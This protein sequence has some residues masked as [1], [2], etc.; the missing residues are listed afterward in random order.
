MNGVLCEV[1]VNYTI[2]GNMVRL[3]DGRYVCS[4]C[5]NEIARADE[6]DVEDGK[7]VLNYTKFIKTGE[8][9]AE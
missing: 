3:N 6:V 8:R 7:V 4:D 5:A 9:T 2:T 1:C